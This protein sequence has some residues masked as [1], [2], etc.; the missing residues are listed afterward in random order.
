MNH[1]VT[2]VTYGDTLYTVAQFSER[3]SHL[4]PSQN[5]VRW[6]LRDRHINGLVEYG[7]AIEV[8]NGGNVPRVL[9]HGPSWF[10]WLRRGGS[11]APKSEAEFSGTVKGGGGC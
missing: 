3:Y 10:E 5:R 1:P 7:A 8:R 9:I 4:Y 2:D 11:C 6:Y